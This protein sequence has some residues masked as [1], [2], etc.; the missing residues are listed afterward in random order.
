MILA[1]ELNN[2][3]LGFILLSLLVFAFLI[4]AIIKGNK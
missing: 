4:T 1:Q 3:T 2:G